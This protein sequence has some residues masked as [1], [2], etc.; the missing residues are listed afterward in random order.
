MNGVK[1]IIDSAF[2]TIEREAVGEEVRIGLF[3]DAFRVFLLVD[4][5]DRPG[6]VFPGVDHWGEG[7][8]LA[9]VDGGWSFAVSTVLLE[10]E[11]GFVDGDGADAGAEALEVVVW[12]CSEMAY[13]VVVDGGDGVAAADVGVAAFVEGAVDVA[14]VVSKDGRVCIVA[15]DGEEVAVGCGAG[16][17]P[18]VVLAGVFGGEEVEGVVDEVCVVGVADGGVTGAGEDEGFVVVGAVEDALEGDLGLDVCDAAGGGVG[19]GVEGDEEV[20]EAEEVGELGAA[21]GV[22]CVGVSL[23]VDVDGFDGEPVVVAPGALVVGGGEVFVVVFGSEEAVAAVGAVVEV[24]VVCVGFVALEAAE[25]VFH[26]S[27]KESP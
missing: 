6:A 3:H 8:I 23:E 5:I 22:W 2:V 14:E 13:G 4:G 25:V 12:L 17:G 1:D 20:F 24:G 21:V 11:G 27:G 26:R 10:A 7:R 18:D 19:V 16:V 9:A 15:V